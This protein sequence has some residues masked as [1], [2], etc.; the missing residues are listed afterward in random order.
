MKQTKAISDAFSAKG[1]DLKAELENGFAG[2]NSLSSEA[3]LEKAFS[4]QVVSMEAGH[5]S[6][7]SAIASEKEM[8][9]S[10]LEERKTSFEAKESALNASIATLQ[11]DK[12]SLLLEALKSDRQTP[13]IKP[14]VEGAQDHVAIWKA[15]PPG[16]EAAAY[17]E[18]FINTKNNHNAS[19][20]SY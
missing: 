3:I 8:L 10:A 1:L 17:F 12:E 19:K 11:A 7:L 2:F 5:A 16:K 20:S 15:M 14:N 9:A 6:A 18:K 13:V 4:E